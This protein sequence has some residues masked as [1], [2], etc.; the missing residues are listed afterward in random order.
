MHNGSLLKE[1][2]NLKRLSQQE[3]GEQIGVDGSQI[4]RYEHKK[5][6]PTDIMV[7][8]AEILDSPEL[9]WEAL[10]SPLKVTMLDNIDNNLGT[11]KDIT[12]CNEVPEMLKSITKLVMIGFFSKLRPS[13]Y[14]EDDRE[15]CYEISSQ[16]M[17]VIVCLFHFLVSL[18]HRTGI[19]LEKVEKDY[20]LKMKA[21]GFRS[22]ENRKNSPAAT[23]E[24]NSSVI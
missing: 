5:V 14:S 19:S 8:A 2:R 23:S 22:S 17:D 7:S 16:V 4:S 15:I 11:I 12:V 21:K 1:K 13:Q 6:V 20:E 10:G 9:R 24:F 3:L 18:K